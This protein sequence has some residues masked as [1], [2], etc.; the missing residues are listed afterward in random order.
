MRS[1]ALGK[2]WDEIRDD[3]SRRWDRLT[4][5]DLDQIAGDAERLMSALRERYEYSREEAERGV[6]ELIEML[7]GEEPSDP[8]REKTREMQ[9]TVGKTAHDVSGRVRVTAEEVSGTMQETAGDVSITV[10][11]AAEDVA[12]QLRQAA[13]DITQQMRATADDVS[14]QFRQATKEVSAEAR[15]AAEIA[16]TRVEARV[17]E[18]PWTSLATAFGIGFFFGLILGKK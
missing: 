16:A 13:D 11:K 8:L 1:E 10:G 6:E 18:S 12:R 15:S 17:V 9:A 4:E 3:V 14:G 2:R 5:A 7:R